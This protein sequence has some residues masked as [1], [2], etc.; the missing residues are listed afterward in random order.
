MSKEFDTDLTD[1]IVCPECGHEESDSWEYG[2]LESSGRVTC[3]RCSREF[4][5]TRNVSITYSTETVEWKLD[6]K[7]KIDRCS[8]CSHFEKKLIDCDGFKYPENH[9][10]KSNKSILV[11]ADDNIEYFCDLDDTEVDE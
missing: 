2:D 6:G 8:L 4:W 11:N 7:K 1:E 10:K 5:A 3:G 9:C